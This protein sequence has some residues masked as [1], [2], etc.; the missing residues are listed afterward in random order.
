[1]NVKRELAGAERRR[2]RLRMEHDRARSR[3]IESQRSELEKLD[4]EIRLLRVEARKAG[5]VAPRG[6]SAAIQAGPLAL[7][8]VRGALVEAPATQASIRKGIGLNPGSVSYA[9]RALLEAGEIRQTRRA[10]VEGSREFQ[11]TA[12]GKAQVLAS[13]A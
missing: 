6:R 13:A 4:R 11:L 3:L 7:S 1:M 10:V 5:V 8:L 9:I 2:E 12:K